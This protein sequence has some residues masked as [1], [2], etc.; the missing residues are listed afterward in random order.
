[1]P[2]DSLTQAIKREARRL[3]FDD[4]RALPVQTA[5]HAD[6][7]EAWLAAGR[8]GEMTYLERHQEKRRQPA[9]LASPKTP[10]FQ[11]MLV[12]TVNYYQFD[13]PPSLRD[14]PSRGII[15][16]Y[17][18]GDDYH[19]IMR[20][21]L[22]ELDAF[23]R[24]QTGR[25]S[26][27]KALV[28]TGPVLE[29]DWAQQAGVGFMGKNCCL[30]HPRDGSWLFLATLLIP[31]RL[32]YDPPP[33]ALPPHEPTAQAVMAGLPPDQVYG[34]WY[35]SPPETPERSVVATCGR[36]TRCLDA[37]PTAAFVGPYHL[38][39]Q[40]CISYWTIEA[41]GPIPRALRARFGNR[42]FGCDICQEVCPWNRRLSRQTPL[43]KGLEAHA[44]RI[45]PP[46]LEGFAAETPYWLQPAAFAEHFRHSPILRAGRAGMLRNV[47]VALGNWGAVEAIPALGQA[48][49]DPE[50]LPRG[51]AAWALGRIAA[52]HPHSQARSLLAAALETEADPWVQEEIHLALSTPSLADG[53]SPVL[54]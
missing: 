43:L 25:A 49:Q 6:F 26:L 1:M 47:C 10:P 39:P 12:L 2:T 54:H 42:I 20:P 53:L 3:G 34:R 24:T 31:E 50:P 40:R 4:C 16:S 11:T 23:I 52:R 15:A 46:L 48:L 22:Y 7:F 32:T 45:A 33:Q 35:L 9:L 28:D 8:A 13:L 29:R 37:C 19:E 17:A 21:L 27:G 30:I 41:R 14:D 38:D 44:D 5:P 18:W 36:C 51:H